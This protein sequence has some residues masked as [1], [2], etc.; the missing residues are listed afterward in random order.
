MKKY[1]MIFC[2]LLATS[3][4]A[5][6]AEVVSADSKEEAAAAITDESVDECVCGGINAFAGFRVG[7]GVAYAN[8]SSEA[9]VTGVTSD[10]LPDDVVRYIQTAT[11]CGTQGSPGSM[12]IRDNCGFLV[13]SSKAK[14]AGGMLGLAYGVSVAD[15]IVYSVELSSVITGSQRKGCDLYL[16][17]YGFEAD[18]AELYGFEKCS[19]KTSGFTPM[20]MAKAGAY[21]NTLGALFSV[22]L[23][24]AFVMSEAEIQ[25][26][27][28][29]ISTVVPAVG[30]EVAKHLRDGYICALKCDFFAS[31]TKDGVQLGKVYSGNSAEGKQ[32]VERSVHFS[33]K[34]RGYNVGIMLYKKF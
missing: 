11:N 28:T 5:Y 6:G 24:G 14:K 15:S 4:F 27:K 17:P 1:A 21:S 9:V 26:T 18:Y 8:R 13:A 31:K 25:G 20:L 29:K 33:N 30:V 12:K 34:S 22:G 10:V 16:H 7:L 23:G 2:G 32:L 3:Q 19:A